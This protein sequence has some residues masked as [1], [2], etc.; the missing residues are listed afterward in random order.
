MTPPQMPSP[1]ESNVSHLSL[2]DTFYKQNIINVEDNII[3]ETILLSLAHAE[4]LERQ[5]AKQPAHL[6]A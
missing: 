6:A 4:E 5:L 3:V 2:H 1:T